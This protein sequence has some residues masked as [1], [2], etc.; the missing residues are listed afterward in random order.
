MIQQIDRQDLV[1]GCMLGLVVGDALGVPFDVPLG[2]HAPAVAD[3]VGGGAFNLQPGE[4]TADTSMA[5]CL[6]E[7][8][9]RRNG[10]HAEDQMERYCS[11]FEHGVWSCRD[12]CFGLEE[13]MRRALL[14]YREGG[15][16]QGDAS[17]RHYGGVLVRIAPIALFYLQDVESAMLY[18]AQ[19]TQLT[20]PDPLCVDA[21]R[22]LTAL[23]HGAMMGV[24][25][26]TLL[27]EDF[28]PEGVSWGAYR[29][30]PEINLL[31][32]GLYQE[33]PSFSLDKP[34]DLLGVLQAALWAFAHSRHFK[35]G[36]LKAVNL[37]GKASTVGA[38]YGQLAGAYYGAE[39]MPDNWL[40]KIAHREA[41][42]DISEKLWRTTL[43]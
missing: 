19:S 13:P 18:A 2:A 4:W 1:L 36:A 17:L 3:M 35:D 5:M 32:K 15:K 21:A 31:R 22:Y 28:E 6:A 26:E 16:L 39:R 30:A 14:V 10:F 40:R 37:A 42:Q 29:L 24:S 43:I 9:L 23:V 33:K 20:H 41:I 25:K 34:D 27:S 12:F 7:S 8:L 38:I 11:S